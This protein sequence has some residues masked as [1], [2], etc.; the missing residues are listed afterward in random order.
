MKILISN[1][2]FDR[3]IME[4]QRKYIGGGVH[5]KV[6]NVVSQKKSDD[7]NF[8]KN[9]IV[10]E[11]NEK[12]VKIGKVDDIIFYVKQFEA[13]PHLFPKVIK[14]GTF[15]TKKKKFKGENNINRLGYAYIEKLDVD[16]FEKRYKNL[17]YFDFGFSGDKEYQIS[18]KWKQAIRNYFFDVPNIN[19][20]DETLDL[21]MERADDEDK[22]FFDNLTNILEEIYSLCD[23]GQ[24][25][26]HPEFDKI[27]LHQGNFGIDKNGEIKC[28]DF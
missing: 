16:E 5:H 20:F 18:Q 10:T 6:Y 22:A 25:C 19:F 4:S 13:Y 1:K 15:I 3:L 9:F 12:I 21:F 24:I 7:E 2:Q 17:L 27:D 28:L 11:D 26:V 8:S 23:D 14:H